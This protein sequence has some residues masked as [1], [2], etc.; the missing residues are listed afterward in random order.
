MMAVESGARMR[1]NF[2]FAHRLAASGSTAFSVSP[3]AIQIL[4]PS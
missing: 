1:R 3:V 2:D 4:A